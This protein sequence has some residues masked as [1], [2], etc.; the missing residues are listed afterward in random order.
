MTWYDLIW[1]VSIAL[2]WFFRPRLLT[3]SSYNMTSWFCSRPAGLNTHP[4]SQETRTYTHMHTHRDPCDC[5]EVMAES[6]RGRQSAQQ[7][8]R[9]TA[10]WHWLTS[11]L[12]K[13]Y[14]WN[15]VMVIVEGCVCVCDWGRCVTKTKMKH[16]KCIYLYISKETWI[17]A[18]INPDF[19]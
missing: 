18:N 16:N 15:V 1:I 6:L 17:Y 10:R 14:R 19:K 13:S 9:K 3:I 11:E 8:G 4:F 7:A 12:L 2:L 5:N